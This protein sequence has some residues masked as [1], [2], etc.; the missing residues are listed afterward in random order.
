L[1]QRLRR[2]LLLL[3][4]LLVVGLVLFALLRPG[5]QGAALQGQRFI[6]LLD[7][8]ASMASTDAEGGDVRLDVAKRRI[9][10][11][12]DQLDGDM[13]AMIVT[14]ADQPD[15]L[16]EFTSSRRLLRDALERVV[17]T[18]AG[19]QI[20]GAL[21][22]ADGFANPVRVT[23]EEGGLE[24]DATAQQPVELMILS[25]GR[26][27]RVDGFSL[28]NLQP[29]FFPVGSLT[30]GNLAIT[31]FNVRRNEARPE[32]RQAFVQVGNFSDASQEVV[33]ELRLDGQLVDA[34]RVRCP[35]GDLTGAAFELGDVAAGGLEAR[36]D[37]PADF[38]DALPL[39]DRAYAVVERAREV[40]VL[41]VTAGNVAL[42]SALQTDRAQRT[43]RID[44][45]P[46]ADL[47][48]PELR[49]LLD[50]G[51][52]DLVVF[53]A[54]APETMPAANTLF[55]GRLPPLAAWGDAASPQVLATP[56]I[57]D[58]QREHPLLNLVELGNVQIVDAVRVDPPP[59]GRVLVDSTAGGLVATAPRDQFEDVVVGFEIVGRN[60][61][62]AVTINTNWPRRMSFPSFW[63]N[64]LEY[65]GGD[66]ADDNPS[67]RAGA[68]VEISLPPGDG[69][70]AVRSPDGGE[71]SVELDGGGKLGW[72]QTD[73]LGIYVVLRDGQPIARFAVN[74]LDP[75]E[76]DVRLR[77]RQDDPQGLEQVDA[78]S[79]GYVD[80][81][82]E[83]LSAPVRQ[84]LWPALVLAALAVVLLEWYIYNRRVYV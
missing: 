20:R 65:L 57:I 36:L 66:L 30:S 15:V 3:L 25:D 28:G 67:Y 44:R 8:S 23:I 78:L 42:E 1:W 18:A 70:H 60:Q 71:T 4:Q 68:P 37:L 47:A 45:R 38:A 53:D 11:L 21:E 14:F 9:A 48:D 26:F 12:I 35:A 19:T 7:R 31:A 74:L 62:G 73:Q 56:Q 81:E 61:E 51:A 46:P 32:Q 40:R 64:A 75:Q 54:C 5:W 55:V 39:D 63:L 27:E 29:K 52:Y 77:P 41:L 50:A 10:E 72:L 83:A 2:S 33:V 13:S 84:E 34:A 6:F 22:L 58:W 49:R 82:A 69:R 59:G 80:V 76:S 16:Q 79:I 43:A 17:P 24:V